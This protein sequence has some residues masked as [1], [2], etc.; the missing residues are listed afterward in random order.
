V[1][2]E[3][4]LNEQISFNSIATLIATTLNASKPVKVSS[5]E[6]V[7]EVDAEARSAARAYA[8]KYLYKQVVNA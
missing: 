1:A 7:I 6:H 8:T 4:F 5:L 3:L 2:V